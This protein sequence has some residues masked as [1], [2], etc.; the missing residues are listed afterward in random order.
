MDFVGVIGEVVE[1][2]ANIFLELRRPSLRIRLFTQSN[3]RSTNPTKDT[4]DLQ[5][6]VSIEP[7]SKRCYRNQRSRTTKV[8]R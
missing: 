5:T 4:A 6:K 1:K 3:P 8:L 2:E 7:R